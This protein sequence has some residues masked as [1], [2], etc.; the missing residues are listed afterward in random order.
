MGTSVELVIINLHHRPLTLRS[1]L[2]QF[3]KL[4]TCV[5]S[6]NWNFFFVI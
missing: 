5:V 3:N 1:M 2:L 4:L 6:Y